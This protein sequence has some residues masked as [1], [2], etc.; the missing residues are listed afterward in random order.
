MIGLDTNV[1]VRVAV[2]DH[3]EQTIQAKARLKSLTLAEPG[4]V[5]NVVMV[6]IWWVLTRAYKKTPSETAAFL[7]RLSEVAT[8]VIQDQELVAAA[9]AAVRDHKA[10]FSDALIAAV[11]QAH[12]CSAVDTFDTGAIKRAGMVPVGAEPILH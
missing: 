9:L 4:F 7:T 3:A 5:S 8:L 1:L 6:E 12:N 10:D 11:A 2:S